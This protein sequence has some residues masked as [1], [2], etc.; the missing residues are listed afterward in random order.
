MRLY[1]NHGSTNA[2]KV[3]ILLEELGA[4]CERVE[5]AIGAERPADYP[6][7]FGMVP[8]LVDGDVV[9]T[10]SNVML[11]YLAE[12]AARPDLRGATPGERAR[13]DVLLDSLS[14]ELRPWLW[15]VEEDAIYGGR[16]AEALAPRVEKLS[17]QLTAYEQLLD[18]VGPWAT[19]A[20]FTIADC[21]LGGRAF[22]LP[23]LPLPPAVAPRLRRVMAALA[24]RPAFVRATSPA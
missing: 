3:R 13:I 20:T 24:E 10:E 9:I 19:G 8:V 7:P 16:A 1:D 23:R 14:L 12:V 22:H 4:G 11:R 6:H 2:I 5:T 17:A 18:P 15:A 21:A